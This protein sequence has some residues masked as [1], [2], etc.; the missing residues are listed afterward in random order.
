MFDALPVKPARYAAIFQ[1]RFELNV[2]ERF[3]LAG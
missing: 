3:R 1:S 2:V